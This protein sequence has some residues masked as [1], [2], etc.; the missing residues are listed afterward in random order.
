M[1]FQIP[2]LVFLSFMKAVTF[3]CLQRAA[4][5]VQ[6]MI[7]E[8]LKSNLQD[9]GWALHHSY[10][11]SPPLAIAGKRGL[12][13]AGKNWRIRAGINS[14]TAFINRVLTDQK[15]A[16][17]LRIT[18]ARAKRRGQGNKREEKRSKVKRTSTRLVDLVCV[19]ERAPHTNTCTDT[20]HIHTY[21][22]Q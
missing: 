20:Q 17:P 13:C 2:L 16:H 11:L 15:A 12:S 5:C 19:K 10:Q 3:G 8:S 21:T 6:E 9:R 1:Y 7:L 14:N 22:R 18:H 4:Y